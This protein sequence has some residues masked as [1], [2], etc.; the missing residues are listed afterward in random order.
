M[1]S[2]I[3]SHS[4]PIGSWMGQDESWMG[5]NKNIVEGKFKIFIFT[6]WKKRKKYSVIYIYD[7]HSEKKYFDIYDEK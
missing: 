2:Y 7:E 4:W 3:L 6:L 5:Q 1:V